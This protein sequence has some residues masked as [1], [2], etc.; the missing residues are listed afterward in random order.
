MEEE[1]E[2]VMVLK[3]PSGSWEEE[4]KAP[5]I[6][7]STRR[8]CLDGNS[9]SPSNVFNVKL[10]N[11]LRQSA[12]EAVFGMAVQQSNSG[13][14]QLLISPRATESQSVIKFLCTRR[15]IQARERQSGRMT[16]RWR[17]RT[18]ERNYGLWGVCVIINWHLY[19]RGPAACSR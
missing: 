19:Y 3:V 10:M 1:V 15:D 16:G 11:S 9:R 7:R 6:A 13:Q 14:F 2:A 12:G 4:R 18:S 17:T 5:E 8:M